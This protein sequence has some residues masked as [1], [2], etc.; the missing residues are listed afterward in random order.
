MSFPGSSEAWWPANNHQAI[1]KPEHALVTFDAAIATC[2]LGTQLQ[3]CDGNA[4][5]VKHCR[6]DVKHLAN[7]GDY[8]MADFSD[9]ASFFGSDSSLTSLINAQNL[10]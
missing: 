9:E 8:S 3:Q 10:L 2:C 7:Y 4:V 1:H 6:M 5:C